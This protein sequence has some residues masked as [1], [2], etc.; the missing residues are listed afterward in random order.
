M[1]SVIQPPFTLKFL[2]MS[3]KELKDYNQWFL[4]SIPERIQILAATVKSTEGFEDWEPDCS[5]QSL[6]TLGEWFARQVETRQLGEQEI[7]EI[8]DKQKPLK[9]GTQNF[10]SGHGRSAAKRRASTTPKPSRTFCSMK[11]TAAKRRSA[12]SFLRFSKCSLMRQRACRRFP[13]Q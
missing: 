9:V 6:E 3:K 10:S 2:E 8:L 12:T 5:P 4:A 1:Y 13:S 11:L 7:Q